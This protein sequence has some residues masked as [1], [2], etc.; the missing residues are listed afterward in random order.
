ML[1]EIDDAEEAFKEL[2]K[3]SEEKCE[4][5]GKS[6]MKK[7]KVLRTERQNFLINIS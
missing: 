2:E 4:Q 5:K 1:Y 6:L 7:L 3:K